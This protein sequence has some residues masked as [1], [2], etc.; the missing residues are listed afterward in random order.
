M[1]KSLFRT[2]R[3]TTTEEKKY[4]TRTKKRKKEAIFST[5]LHTFVTIEK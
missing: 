5:F 2:A 3:L 1:P 4:H